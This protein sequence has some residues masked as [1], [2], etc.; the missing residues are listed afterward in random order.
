[1]CYT[2]RPETVK[3]LALQVLWFEGGRESLETLEKSGRELSPE[4]G[5][6]QAD[7]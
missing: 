6:M 5:G 4:S 7:Q 1:M 2:G 3:C